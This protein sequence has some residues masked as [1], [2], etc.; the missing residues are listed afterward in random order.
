MVQE[1]RMSREG[2]QHSAGFKAKV[3]LA[4]AKEVRTVGELAL[5]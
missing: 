2:N 1:T 3:A 4:A 5:V